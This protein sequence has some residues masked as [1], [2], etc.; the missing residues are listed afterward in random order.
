M[1]TATIRFVMAFK[2][3]FVPAEMLH[4]CLI[5]LAFGL[6]WLGVFALAYFKDGEYGAP[7]SLFYI[8]E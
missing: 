3:T 6:L 1:L 5:P 8:Q 2:Q 4:Y 7:P